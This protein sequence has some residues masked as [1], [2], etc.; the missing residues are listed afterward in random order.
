MTKKVMPFLTHFYESKVNI[1]EVVYVI[2]VQKNAIQYNLYFIQYKKK[3][4]FDKIIC[5]GIL[6]KNINCVHVEEI[7]EQACNKKNLLT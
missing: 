5:P 4:S 2:L 3:G 1:A 6:F 7:N